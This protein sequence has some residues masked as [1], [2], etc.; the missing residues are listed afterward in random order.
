MH[1]FRIVSQG[2][3]LILLLFLVPDKLLACLVE[4]A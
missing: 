2:P 3:L 1:E 4:C